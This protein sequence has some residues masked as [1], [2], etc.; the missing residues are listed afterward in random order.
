M[1][2]FGLTH[3]ND[4]IF[5]RYFTGNDS[6]IVNLTE[7]TITIPNHFYV[8]GEKIEYH[9]VG[10]TASSVGVATTSFTVWKHNIL[11]LKI[12]LQLKLMITH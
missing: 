5:E 9:H 8:S 6:N 3:D 7:N 11:P 2:T 1:R 10:T 4:E 12:Y